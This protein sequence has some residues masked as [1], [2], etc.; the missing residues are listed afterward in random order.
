ME[1]TSHA[2]KNRVI[3]RS[4][5]LQKLRNFFYERAYYE[6]DCNAL[7]PTPSIDAAIDLIEVPLQ[8]SYLHS[9]P[10]YGIKR[11]LSQ[12]P[13]TPVFQLSHVFRK[14]EQGRWHRQE[15]MLLEWYNPTLSYRAFQEEVA[16]LLQSFLPHAD[17]Q[18]IP[19]TRL[20]QETISSQWPLSCEA[21]E[22]WLTKH[23]DPV[24]WPDWDS[25]CDY[26][27][28]TYIAPQLKGL[29]CIDRFPASQA[30]LAKLD[31]HGARRFEWLMDG[32]ELANGYDELND[33]KMMRARMIEENRKRVAM[34]KSPYP[35]DEVLYKKID[36]LPNYCGVALGV[37][38]LLACSLQKTE[39]RDVIL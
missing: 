22:A 27:L 23:N 14:E 12:L 38:R 31:I 7:E 9:S 35:L 13:P 21:I 10:E 30:A 3:A 17:P 19:H 16:A 18:W 34:G 20:F 28:S 36:Q 2:F 15:F 39:L 4:R 1:A 11:L 32:L 5:A 25:Y 37:D 33:G 24:R 8:K 6:V 26:L 29:W